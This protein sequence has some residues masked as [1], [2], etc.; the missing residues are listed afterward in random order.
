MAV[1]GQTL[2]QIVQEM[3]DNFARGIAQDPQDW[4]LLQPLWFAD[5]SQSRRQRL[6][7]EESP[8]EDA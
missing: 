1:D 7:L 4:H 6:G 5:L 2:Q 3:A 8:G